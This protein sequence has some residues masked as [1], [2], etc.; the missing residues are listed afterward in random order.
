[1][2]PSIYAL[3]AVFA[4]T[5]PTAA[6]AAGGPRD[7]QGPLD[8]GPAEGEPAP[9]APAPE[10][11]APEA[12][13][14]TPPAPAPAPA[15]AKP[16]A[17]AEEA[18]DDGFCVE[19]LTED[20]EALKRETE[21]AK[22]EVKGP[23]G[24]IK[25]RLLDS[26]NATPLI[27]ATITVEGTE[28]IA[29]SDF[30]GNYELQL[31]P[32]TYTVKIWYD[33]YEGVTVSNVAVAQ[34]DSQTLNRELKPIAGMAQTVVVQA[35]INKESSA[36]K[37]AERKKSTAARDIMSRA[38]FAKSGGGA[39]SAV[40]QRIVG[41][42]VVGGR[43]LFIRGLGHRYG[44]TLFDGAR[45]PSPDPNLR[46]VPLDIFP[47]TALGAINIQ[48]TFTP[49]VPADFAGGS[50]QLESRETPEAWT[51]QL[52]AFVG[53]N[54]ATTGRDGVIGDRFAG[55]RFAF[56]NLGR[57]LG[58]SF[59][60]KNPIDLNFQPPGSLDRAWTNADIE[61]FGESL[62]STRTALHP[63]VGLPNFGAAAT[64]GNTFKP[65]GTRLGFLAAA[66]Y[67]SSQ[68]TLRETIRVYNAAGDPQPGTE[69]P[70]NVERPRVDY[71]SLKTTYNTNWSGIGVFKWQLNDNHRLS[72]VGMYTRDADTEVRQLDGR[73]RPTANEQIVRNTRL[74]YQMRSIAF[75][76]LGGRHELPGAKNLRVDWFGSFAQARLADPLLREMLFLDQ[77]GGD[78]I[79][80]QRESGKFQFFNLV[81][82]TAT[83]ALD[84]TLPFKQWGQLDAKLK[85][86]GWAEG[87]QRTF[88]TRSF[89]FQVAQG[90]QPQI[91]TGTGDILGEGTIGGGVNADN[92]GT[93]PFYL[94]EI[95]RAN[96]SYTG[97]QR[98]F[99]GY[100]LLD[101]PLVRW[102]RVVGGARFESSRIQ[103]SPFDRFGRPIAAE[104][105]ANVVDNKVLPSASLIFPIAVKKGDM[106]LRLGGA[107]TLARPEFRELA[108]FLF[109]DFVGGFDV[110]GNTK[111]R[112]TDIWNADLRLEWFP[113]ASEVVAVS[114]FYKYFDSPIERVIGARATPLQG[115]FNAKSAQ[116]IGAELE[117]RK[118]LE[119]LHKSIRDLSLGANFTY[120][121][122]RVQFAPYEAGEPFSYS[123]PD[124]PLEGQSPYVVNTYLSYDRE[125]SGTSARVLFNTYGKRIA[126]VG[127]QGLPNIYE[128]PVHS[129]DLTLQQRVHKNLSLY[130][131]GFNLLNWRRR[132]VQGDE[133]AVTYNTLRGVTFVL[134]L[135]YE[136]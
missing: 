65:W 77:G 102:L 63:H 73:S 115:Y 15:P 12:P 21:V 107:K 89:D 64:V 76:R 54:T 29:K 136:R 49:D 7:Y 32:G 118:S 61:K 52:R 71:Q 2:D 74:R 23:T 135:T 37:L 111:L 100:A 103:V 86:G 78:Y 99:A 75:T 128:L 98:I 34:D 97:H 88:T 101:L 81:D 36:G 70:L 83:G 60:T 79:V 50:T 84:L 92:G 126:F 119:F 117:F 20:P 72:A 17:P 27:G 120:V 110:F 109:T 82:N 45:V 33:T 6:S 24:T 85:F 48:K 56:G 134:G 26:T 39:T 57:Q 131:N 30:D 18:C 87:K 3:F 122:S 105:N 19:D 42:T 43:F 96:D 14:E 53:A 90:L 95:T 9:E 47:S 51:L 127:G 133:Q 94:Q 123:G 80:D 124:R 106:N 46:T 104:D 68:Q 11:P 4:L 125:K 35:E 112:T 67:Q 108:P 16:A 55:D 5:L 28:Y 66:Q 31:P 132:F 91:P 10:A 38:D 129:L 13:A 22:V 25:G 44:N 1:M 121:Y 93:Q 8:L 58:P 130:A 114:A 116:N 59:D 113:S 40:A 41:I 62:P 69:L